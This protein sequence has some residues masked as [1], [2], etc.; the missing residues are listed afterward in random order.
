MYPLKQEKE[1]QMAILSIFGTKL[2]QAQSFLLRE[3]KKGPMR[4]RKEACRA[5]APCYHL[6]PFSQTVQGGRNSGQ[7]ESLTHKDSARGTAP[8]S[9][10]GKYLPFSPRQ[11]VG[12]RV[13][14]NDI[15]DNNSHRFW[16]GLINNV[17]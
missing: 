15:L 14:Y 6:H 2:E 3:S 11:T 1:D 9:I 10:R 13:E 5:T 7:L 12:I 16:G 8:S 4:E 17:N